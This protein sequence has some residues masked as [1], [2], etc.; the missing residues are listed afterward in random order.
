ML[1]HQYGGEAELIPV[2]E[3][4]RLER[5]KSV[6]AEGKQRAA[7]AKRSQETLSSRAMGAGRYE[8][9]HGSS[10]HTNAC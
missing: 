10:Y 7:A 8:Q 9:H 5:H 2:D 3:A 4:A 1:P 6:L